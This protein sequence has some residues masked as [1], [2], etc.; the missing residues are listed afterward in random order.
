MLFIF[1]FQ[2]FTRIFFLSIGWKFV[3]LYQMIPATIHVYRL[4]L[5]RPV[6]LRTLLVVSVFVIAHDLPMIWH[7]IFHQFIQFIF[8]AT[9]LPTMIFNLM[10][11]RQAYSV[12][13]VCLTTTHIKF[14][15]YCTFSLLSFYRRYII[16]AKFLW[17]WELN[18]FD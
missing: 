3:K 16:F 6:Y 2:I 9:M 10:V 4:L 11:V 7:T 13:S 8:L 15:F 12:Q 18:E 5:K 1:I 17:F 14:L